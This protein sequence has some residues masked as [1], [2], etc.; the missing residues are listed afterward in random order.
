MLEETLVRHLSHPI[1]LV[2]IKGFL[3]VNTNNTGTLLSLQLAEIS[4]GKQFLESVPWE[5]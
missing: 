3:L 4:H 2:N 5:F 1:M